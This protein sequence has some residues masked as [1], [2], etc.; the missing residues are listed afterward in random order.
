ME[1]QMSNPGFGGASAKVPEVH[2]ALKRSWC[3]ARFELGGRRELP[4]LLSRP[5]HDR[6]LY[7]A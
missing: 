5:R 3:G 2:M 7:D 1:V 6:Y 4:Q